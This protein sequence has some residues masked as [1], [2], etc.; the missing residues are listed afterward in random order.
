M[1]RF[2]FATCLVSLSALATAYAQP[3]FSQERQMQSKEE[4]PLTEQLSTG[5]NILQEN[6]RQSS[7]QIESGGQ[8][9]I[10]LGEPLQNPYAVENMQKAFNMYSRSMDTSGTSVQATHKYIEISPNNE[11]HIQLLDK[12]DAEGDL[13]FHDYP[14]DREVTTEGD[15]YVVPSNEQDLYHPIYTVIPVD[16]QF[17]EALPYRVIEDVYEPEEAEAEVEA[18]AVALAGQDAEVPCPKLMDC[19]DPD[20]LLEMFKSPMQKR[21]FGGRKYR[22]QGYVKVKNTDARPNSQDEWE[23][24][25][26]AKISVGRGI[27]WKYTYTDEKGYFKAPKRYRGKVRI[28][29]KWRSDTATIRKSWNEMLGVQVSDHLM[30]I[31]KSNNG[32]T[33]YIEPNDKKLWFKGTVHNGLVKYNDYAAA[34]GIDEPIRDANVWVWENG[35]SAASAPMLFKH[36]HLHLI[37]SAANMG[38]SNAWDVLVN[39]GAGIGIDLVPGHLRPDMVYSGLKEKRANGQVS[40]ARIQQQAFH[41]SAH[42]SHAVKAGQE[43]WAR[44]FAAEL[45][46]DIIH[47][48]PYVDGSQPSLIRGKLIALAEGWATF[49]EYKAMN[50]YFGRVYDEGW[51]SDPVSHMERFDM[52][53]TP[54]LGERSDTESWFLSGLIWDIQD[55]ANDNTNN[56]KEGINGSNISPLTDT[57]TIRSPQ[58]ELHPVFSGLVSS[59]EDACDYGQYLANTY[60]PG[61]AIKTLFS[62]YGYDCVQVV[63]VPDDTDTDDGGG[64]GGNNTIGNP[65]GGVEIF[66]DCSYVGRQQICK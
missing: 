64:G 3:V 33:K 28:R 36:R 8:T 39:V 66:G 38:S 17:P 54:M 29:S 52:Y 19:N 40:T 27:W 26:K 41:E 59:V 22:P 14:L 42:Y 18:V 23:P 43:L 47:G 11:S 57:L 62:S 25:E 48:D 35:D 1:H 15:Y 12:L 24:L 4:Q 32:R 51:R 65:R 63:S 5:R 61:A 2:F 31:T 60:N 37:A 45:A 58:G 9:Q 56:L 50:H 16:Y 7:H 6:V 20:V 44:V 13:V 49:V 34:K 55:T 21:I 53:T 10:V 30:T 46:N